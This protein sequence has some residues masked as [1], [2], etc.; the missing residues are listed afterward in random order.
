MRGTSLIPR[1]GNDV[2]F[3]PDDVAKQ[4]VDS[5]P[6]M[7]SVLEPCKGAGAFLRAF[8]GVKS[9]SSV[10]W[11]ELSEGVDFF[12]YRGKVG[13]IITNPP[14]SKFADFLEHSMRVADNVVFLVTVNHFMTKKRIRL[15]KEAGFWFRRIEMIP[16]PKTFPQ[17]GFQVAVVWIKKGYNGETVIL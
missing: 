15:M 1:S 10:E 12:D 11:C 7:G 14:F 17:S 6:V 3:T 8:E 16:T 5:L 9:I 13:W 4:I 2:V